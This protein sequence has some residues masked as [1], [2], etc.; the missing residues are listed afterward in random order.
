M[1]YQRP[2]A[3][4]G[5]SVFAGAPVLPENHIRGLSATLIATRPAVPAGAG[6]SRSSCRISADHP[7]RGLPIDPGRTGDRIPSAHPLAM[8]IPWC[9][10]PS[11]SRT[12]TS[13]ACSA[14]LTTSG[15]RTA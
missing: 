2:L 7:G 12:G 11:G 1:R 15:P 9:V 8:T 5:S 6:S 10:R 13:S 14:Q 4:K 3:E